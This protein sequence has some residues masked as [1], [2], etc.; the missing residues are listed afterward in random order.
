MKPQVL[1]NPRHP[2]KTELENQLADVLPDHFW[3]LTSGSTG[4]SKAVALSQDALFAS[5]RAVNAHLQ[6]TQRDIW[7]NCLPPFHVGGAGILARAHLSG[8]KVITLPKWD[9]HALSENATLTALV[10][11]QIYDL[12]KANL[13]APKN[14][15]AV[16]VGGGA[17]PLQL[18]TQAKKLHWPLLPSYGL[19]ECASQVATAHA[20]ELQLL[21][22]IE[23]KIE[24]GRLSIKS[25]SLL[26]AYALLEDKKITLEDPKIDGWFLTEDCA[27]L[28]GR[29]LA[30]TGRLGDFVKIGGE[31]VDLA[32]LNALIESLSSECALLAMP[33]ERLGHAL[34]LAYTERAELPLILQRYHE[35]VLPF[36]KIRD[37]H[38][39]D[40]IPRSPLGKILRGEILFHLFPASL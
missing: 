25:P 15:R 37:T 10:P 16:I 35:Q 27:T 22:H 12:V 2:Q 31:S 28:N 19:T 40:A 7:L 34:H 23:A 38:L 5:A 21:P 11:T 20:Y 1:I 3:F 14:L 4:Q 8:S 26:T 39:V 32:K 29:T 18:Y 6:A 13:T 17:L 30:I 9:P 33:D 36:E 24:N